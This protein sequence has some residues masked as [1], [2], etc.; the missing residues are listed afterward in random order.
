MSTIY[1]IFGIVFAVLG[2][3]AIVL[4]CFNV[5]YMKRRTDAECNQPAVPVPK[6]VQSED[7]TLRVKDALVELYET[8]EENAVAEEIVPEQPEQDGVFIPVIEKLT[9]SE[10]Y[11]KLD[12]YQKSLLDEFVAYVTGKEN[13][14]KQLQVSS[15]VI[16]YKKTCVVRSVIRRDNVLLQFSILDPD[17]GRLVREERTGGLKVKPVEV[18]LNS[19]EALEAAKQTADMTV[20]YLIGEEAYRLE[21]RKEARREAQRKKREITES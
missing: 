13:C 1:I 7:L 14:E 2:V 21:K 3:L 9:F 8:P 15:L 10:K 16:K 18:R 5:K 17:F 6:E 11:D 12:R 4:F 20:E 19:R